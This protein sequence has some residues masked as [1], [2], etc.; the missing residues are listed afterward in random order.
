MLSNKEFNKALGN[1]T[2]VWGQRDLVGALIKLD[3]L[4]P[5]V[6]PEMKAHCLL[7]KGTILKE[8]ELPSDAR[9]EWLRAIPYSRSGSFVRACLEYEIG[10]SFRN[11]NLVDEARIYYRSA[12]ETCTSGDEFSGNKSLS[13]F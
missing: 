8:Q 11:E 4:I 13:A 12:I 6:T 5:N 9:Q 3:E 10:E 2:F 1:I 7:F